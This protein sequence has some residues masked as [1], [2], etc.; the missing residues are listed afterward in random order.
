MK[1]L[2]QFAILLTLAAAAFAQEPALKKQELTAIKGSILLPEGWFLKEDTDDGLTIYQIS[3]EKAEK[4]GDAFTAGLILTVTPKVT[5]RAEVKPSNYA[6]DLLPSGD[7]DGAKGMIK[8]EE[9]PVKCFRVEYAIDG[10]L[11][12]IK[13]ITIAKANDS[14]GTLYFLTWQSPETEDAALKD[15]REKILASFTIDPAF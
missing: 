9:G 8:T 11:S 14:T 4:E 7:D 12:D 5:E 3:R 13:I 2:L 1:L 6:L 15:L 10:E